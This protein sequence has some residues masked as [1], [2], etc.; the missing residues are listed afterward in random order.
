MS[1]WYSLVGSSPCRQA[2][3]ASS[4]GRGWVRNKAAMLPVIV[5]RLGLVDKEGGG[6]GISEF[7]DARLGKSKE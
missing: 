7:E 1:S 3:A 6:S 2:L 5:D 4:G